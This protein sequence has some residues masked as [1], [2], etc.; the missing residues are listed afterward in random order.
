MKV[1]TPLLGTKNPSAP[2]GD[3]SGGDIRAARSLLSRAL[4]RGMGRLWRGMGGMER[5]EPLAAHHPHQQQ[6]LS[7]FHETRDMNHGLFVSLF[8]IVHHCSPLFGIVQ[9]KILFLSRCPSPRRSLWRLPPLAPA[10]R[11][12]GFSRDTNHG[13]YAFH[14]TRDTNHESRPLC[15]SSHDFPRF[16]GI[17]RYYSAPPSPRK[18]CPSPVSRSRWVSRLA[19]ISHHAARRSA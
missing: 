13:F 9:Q 10:T 11:P 7:G 3:K 19:C 2:V 6:G 4:W 1:M 16:P 17:S 18:R 8:T 14:E 15:F 5:P 12:L